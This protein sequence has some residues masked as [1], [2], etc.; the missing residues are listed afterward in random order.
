MTVERQRRVIVRRDN[1]AVGTLDHRISQALASHRL[2]QAT[3]GRADRL[4]N[5]SQA[6]SGNSRVMMSI[7][8]GMTGCSTSMFKVVISLSRDIPADQYMIESRVR[9][10]IQGGPAGKS[11]NDIDPD[12][13]FDNNVFRIM[14]SMTA[15]PIPRSVV[16]DS[17]FQGLINAGVALLKGHMPTVDVQL[18]AF[19]FSEQLVNWSATASGR[20]SGAGLLDVDMKSAREVLPGLNAW[21]M[22]KALADFPHDREHYENNPVN[23]MADLVIVKFCADLGV[24]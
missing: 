11:I 24:E 2:L 21:V 3:T 23:C 17:N 5:A 7:P 18:W 22:T 19:E 15:A 4:L 12:C 1:G 6:S 16:E 13:G 10:V 14:E 9:K 8:D 20:G